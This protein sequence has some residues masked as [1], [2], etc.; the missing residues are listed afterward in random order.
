MAKAEEA[1]TATAADAAKQSR[2]R[3]P[4]YPYLNLPT[5]IE[6]VR[7][8]FKEIGRHP[9]GI[10]VLIG[11]LG[12][13][14]KSSS[15]KKALGALRAFGLVQDSKSDGDQLV[16]L[17]HRALDIV[18]DYKEGDP[19]WVAAVAKAARS[20]KL[21]SLLLQKYENALPPDDELK[22]YLVR[23]YDPPFTDAGAGE[24]IAELRSTLAFSERHSPA[25]DT[26]KNGS[27]P[28]TPQIEVQVG[29][30]VNWTSQGVDQFPE[31]VKV[32]QIVDGPDGKKYA[33]VEAEYEGALPVDQL[34]LESPPAAETP[35]ILLPP[36]PF[37]KKRQSPPENDIPEGIASERKMLD[38][39][40][41]EIRW[42]DQI[43]KESFEEFEYW[44]TG[45]LNRARRKAGVDKKPSDKK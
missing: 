33:Y 32:A 12:Y 23:V 9:V 11:K 4:N 8:L 2:H 18:A 6:K 5:A 30:Y 17:S 34:T 1:A 10:P 20:P 42:P 28:E 31:S 13:T 29:S 27:G 16:K 36:N 43:G 7:L 15:G 41:A 35:A 40:Y 37:F 39:G 25:V 3:S 21:H 44:L 19:E 14:A 22:R 26:S 45:V 24:F 38:E